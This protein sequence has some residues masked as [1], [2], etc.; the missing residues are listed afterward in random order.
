MRQP[1]NISEDFLAASFNPSAI[2]R[3]FGLP[4][5]LSNFAASGGVKDNV[6]ADAIL[7]FVAEKACAEPGS[8][9][10]RAASWFLLY[11]EQAFFIVCAEAGIDAQKLRSHLELCQRLGPDEMGRLL[12]ERQGRDQ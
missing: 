5:P 1:M 7:E 9:M 11:S 8:P 3:R 10:H 4:H 12:E 2:W 6:C